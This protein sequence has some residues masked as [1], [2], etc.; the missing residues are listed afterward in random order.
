MSLPKLPTFCCNYSLNPGL[1]ATDGIGNFDGIFPCIC[2]S[3]P[4]PGKVKN[5]V[6][7]GDS[8]IIDDLSLEN[9]QCGAHQYRDLELFLP[10][11]NLYVKVQFETSAF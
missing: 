9:K 6:A 4:N 3:H 2:E 1:L 7:V 10:S 5:I 11:L 8:S